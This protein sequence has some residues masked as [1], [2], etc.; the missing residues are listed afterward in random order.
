MIKEDSLHRLIQSL[1]SSEK[2][3]FKMYVSNYSTSKDIQ[4]LELFDT[5]SKLDVYDENVLKNKLKN[6]NTI[7][8]LPQAKKYLKDLILKSMRQIDDESATDKVNIL[9]KEASFLSN[10]NMFKE[11]WKKLEKAKE[12]ANKYELFQEELKILDIQMQY[13]IERDFDAAIKR[14]NSYEN[15][16]NILIKKEN[17]FQEM[18]ISK[19]FLFLTIRQNR[20]S[21]SKENKLQVEK[22]FSKFNDDDISKTQSFRIQSLYNTIKALYFNLLK[23]KVKV[24][25]FR[26]N[27]VTLYNDFSHFL[28]VSNSRYIISYFN[29]VSAVFQLEDFKKVEN[30]LNNIENFKLNNQNEKGEFFQNFALYKILLFLN[31]SNIQ[32]AIIFE[33]YVL[34]G[35][36]KYSEKINDSSR[37]TLYYNYSLI[38]FMNAE[39]KKS[40]EWLNKIDTI[41]SNVRKDLQAFSKILA[42][43]CWL[44][45]GENLIIESLSRSVR[46][47]ED[48][49]NY[50][51]FLVSNILKISQ[52]GAKQNQE[53]RFKFKQEIDKL[54]HNKQIEIGIYT[55]QHW[56]ENK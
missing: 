3:L 45:I 56:L 35:L 15:E 27:I 54:I 32:D 1:D 5:F 44:E 18:F 41:K 8:N 25:E 38:F 17:L 39:Y 9:L 12:L 14:I 43:I 51:K 16:K 33:K 19:N 2:R 37:L 31:T 28:D 55:V 30:L 22:I 11:Q 47:G 36:K 53:I 50:E 4:Y 21:F 7:K 52:V 13:L 29:Y 49:T 48:L 34:E 20:R 6:A 42:M 40:L 10:K 23:D 46:R 24:E 26:S